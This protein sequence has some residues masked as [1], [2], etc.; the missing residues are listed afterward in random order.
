MPKAGAAQPKGA[1]LKLR[2]FTFAPRKQYPLRLPLDVYERLSDVC[3]AASMTSTLYIS[4]VLELWLS[5]DRDLTGL[6]VYEEDI[7][8]GRVTVTVRLL[9]SL[10][11]RTQ[12]RA[13]AA[14][15]SMNRLMTFVIFESLQAKSPRNPK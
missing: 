10:F 3:S 15:V 7:E 6:Q 14:G 11:T 2:Q 13:L 5:V 8:S 4:T 1:N 12:A 9:P